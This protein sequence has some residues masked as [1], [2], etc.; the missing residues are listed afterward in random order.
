ML[1]LFLTIA[2]SFLILIYLVK[3]D[4]FPEPTEKII[5]TFLWGIFIIL[6]AAIANDLLIHNWNLLKI[7]VSI[8]HSFL[9]A[10][11][12]E[13]GLKFLILTSIIGKYR[14]YDHPVDGIVYCVC[15]SQGFAT[16]ENIYYVYTL[17]GS[18]F[19]VALLRSISAVPAHA[20]FGAIMG[21]FYSHHLLAKKKEDK[22][23]FF[24]LSIIAPI[25]LHSFYNYFMYTAPILA[26]A[27]LITGLYFSY[28]VFKKWNGK[29][30][31]RI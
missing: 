25:I 11:P 8:S 1:L 24:V 30:K 14:D 26:F 22:K 4:R 13:E 15:L 28:T 18:S 2:P 6:P 27:L 12:I 23:K 3:S 9:S 5:K 7:D 29:R 20:M 19:E 31:F 10:G 16:L 17:Y 21:I